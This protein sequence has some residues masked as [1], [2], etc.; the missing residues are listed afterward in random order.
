M[1]AVLRLARLLTR[2]FSRPTTGPMPPLTDIAP[3]YPYPQAAPNEP[4]T[5]HEGPVAI[6]GGMAGTGRLVLRWLPSAGL[7]LE[8]ISTPCRRPGPATG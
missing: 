5:L 2:L 6:P 8:A 7:R 3:L 1:D 4:V